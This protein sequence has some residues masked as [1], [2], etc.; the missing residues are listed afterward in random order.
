[1]KRRKFLQHIGAGVAIPSLINGFGVKAYANS[2]FPSLANA[3]T[4]DTDHVLVII[5]LNGGNDGLN[6]VT[7]LDQ[8]D[9]LANCRGNVLI[10]QNKLLPISN[11]LALH[12]AMTGMRDLW[13]D[14]QLRIVQSVGYPEQSFSHFR[15]T[16]I[17]MSGSNSDEYFS[18]GWAG[19][20]LNYEYPN[21][22]LDYPNADMPH[23]LAIEIGS[24]LSL[25]LMGPQTGMGFVVYGPDAFYSLLQGTQDPA[26]NTPAGEQLTYIR[27]IAQ[28]SRVYAQA[29]INAYNSVS[30]QPVYPD[31]S[32]AAQLKIV[33]RMIAGGLK[34]RVYVVSISGFDTHDAQVEENDH[35]LGEHA[36]LLKMV[37]DAVKAFTDDLQFQGTADRVVG[38]TISEFGR[39]IVSNSSVG[40]DHGEAAPLFLFGKP[41]QGG[42]LGNNP[43]I[44]QNA[45]EDDNIPMQTDFRSVYSSLL[46]DWF[47]VPEADVPAIMLHDAPFID[48]IQPNVN[49]I[50]TS[51]HQANQEAGRSLL[52][53][54]PNPFR[55]TT[56]VEYDTNGGI[57]Q[58]SILDAKGAEV[59]QLVAA[60]M[61]KG[62]HRVSWNAAGMPEGAYYCTLR[63]GQNIQTKILIKQG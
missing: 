11:N 7:P 8:Y 20:Y 29:L 14:G 6:T 39:R 3:L 13:D 53:F 27:T 17:W 40:T 37:S 12:P 49:C 32:L 52:R 54:L 9:K 16:D 31:N 41:V 44:P 1:M 50:A 63:N 34:T 21:Y 42:V 55:E 59:A 61:P 18:N 28:Q 4:T 51:V 46:R 10:P 45:T 36:N 43:E 5:N 62:T 57:T 25:Q 58:L 2:P 24:S 48:L 35:T 38:M 56:V 60:W 19:R 30:Q 23:P 15:S 22:P 26:P 33:S 47:C